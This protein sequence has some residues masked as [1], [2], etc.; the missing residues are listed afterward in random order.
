M[1]HVEVSQWVQGAPEE[2]YALAS[3]ME[4]YPEFMK[5]VRSVKILD[6]GDAYTITEWITEVDGRVIRWQERDDFYPQEGLIRYHQLSGDLKKFEGYWQIEEKNLNEKKG[7]QITLTVEFDLGIPMLSSL[8]NPL[9]KQKVRA[10]SEA[11]L[12]AIKAQIEQR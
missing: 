4:N 12:E 3:Q 2:V 5:D 7:S 10:N 8:L 6:R 9:L 11:M 1:P